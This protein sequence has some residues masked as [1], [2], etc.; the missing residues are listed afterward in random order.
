[1]SASIPNLASNPNIAPGAMS[2]KDWYEKGAEYFEGGRMAA[3]GGGSSGREEDRLRSLASAS[4]ASSSAE[5]R[6]AWFSASEEEGVE[7]IASGPEDGMLRIVRA[8]R[9]RLR[10]ELRP[11]KLVRQAERKDLARTDCTYVCYWSLDGCAVRG[12]Y[13]LRPFFSLPLCVCLHTYAMMMM[14]YVPSFHSV[15]QI[16]LPCALRDLQ[17]LSRSRSSSAVSSPKSINAS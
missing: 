16:L 9:L 14:I 10:F 12:L 15:T 5:A 4:R 6:R 13:L 8:F 17:C 11:P 1:M 7:D 2:A 3:S